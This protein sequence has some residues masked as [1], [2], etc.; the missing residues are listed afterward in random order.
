MKKSSFARRTAPSTSLSRNSKCNLRRGNELQV[1]GGGLFFEPE[2]LSLA[3]FGFVVGHAL[4]MVGLAELQ[5]AVED[6][7]QLIGHGGDGLRRSQAGAQAA[8][9]G[10]QRALAADQIP[11]RQAQSSG[12]A[13]DHVAG[14]AL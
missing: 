8:E 2:E 1:E 13:V 3:V 10:S 6:S 12:G 11:G 4:V 7:G 9:L 14:S 5:H